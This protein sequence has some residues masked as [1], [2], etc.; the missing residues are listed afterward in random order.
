MP[1]GIPPANALVAEQ[2]AEASQWSANESHDI[3]QSSMHRSSQWDPQ[4]DRASIATAAQPHSW[5]HDLATI[6]QSFIRQIL[7]LN[8]FKTSY[9]S[10]YRPLDDFQSRLIL[11]FAILFSMAAGIPL[12]LIG[13]ILGKI[14]NNFPPSE[15]D[16]NIRLVQLMGTAVGYFA[17]TF[18]WSVC[19]GIVGERVSRKTRE[20]LVERALGMEMSYFDTVSPD[21]T[22]ILTEKTQ[23][24]QLGTSEKVGLFI[25]SISYFLAAFTVGFVLNPRLTAVLF[26]TVIPSMALIVCLGTNLVSRFSKQAAAW[27]EKAAAVAAS[28]IRAV[29]VVQA[30]GVSEQLAKDHHSFLRAALRV[31]IKKSVAGAFMLGSVWFVAYSANALAFWY[32]NYLRFSDGSTSGEAGTIY[33]VVFLILDASFVVGQFGP[34]IQTFALAAAAGQA[35]FSI[36][37]APPSEI[38]VY[39]TQGEILREEDFKQDI[40]LQDVSFVYPARPQMKVLDD[41]TLTFQPGEVTGLVGTSG[42][43]K[44]TITALLLR[45]YD[46]SVGKVMLGT[47]DARTLNLSSLRSHIALVTQTPVLFSGTILDNIKHGISS[48]ETLSDEEILSRCSEAAAE[49]HCDFIAHLP[50]GIHTKVGSGHHSQLSGGQKQ[51]ITLARALVGKPSLLLLDEFTSAM[52]GTSE[53]SPASFYEC[54]VKLTFPSSYE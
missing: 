22:S 7:G 52:D 14:I 27:S 40:S 4:I 38:D 19:W 3:D 23:T 28:A 43:G 24:I 37:D 34:F 20:R 29:Q 44:S 46:P 1:P 17:V 8:P 12:P 2:V 33:A 54:V 10:L 48:R 25:A 50:D 39:S 31:G 6:R 32:G 51:R 13:I 35:V 9:F 36:L 5:H 49:A 41:V 11:V 16:L 21:M 47:K 15:H 26:V 18:G 53:F 30:F 45:M 42:S